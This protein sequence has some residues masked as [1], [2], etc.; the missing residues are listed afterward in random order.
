MSADETFAVDDPRLDALLLAACRERGI[1]STADLRRELREQVTAQSET[2]DRVRR[3][4]EAIV[5]LG[6]CES[7]QAHVWRDAAQR[8]GVDS[9]PARGALL[10]LVR[11]VWSDGAVSVGLTNSEWW[12]ARN[13][14]QELVAWGHTE[15]DALIA[16]L[17]ART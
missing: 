13:R 14:H 10:D 1:T 5:R 2:D 11:E 8:Y 7:E 3:V 16:A 17:E 6:L 4:C 15:L 9:G 12:Q